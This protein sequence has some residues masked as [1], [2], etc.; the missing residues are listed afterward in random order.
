[1][2][3]VNFAPETQARLNRAAAE[4]GTDSAEYVEQLVEHY[5]DHDAWFRQK[6]NNGLRQLDRGQWLSHEDMGARIEEMFR[7]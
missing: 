4:I 6:V 3:E 5:L 1:M 2:M 7:T